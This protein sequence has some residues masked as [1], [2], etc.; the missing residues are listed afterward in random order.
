MFTVDE[1]AKIP[2][3]SALEQN[4]LEYIAGAVEDIHLIPG[5][6]RVAG[7][8]LVERPCAVAV[9]GGIIAAL[10]LRERTA[11]ASAELEAEQ[12]RESGTTSA[13]RDTQPPV[14]AA[15]TQALSPFHV[16]NDIGVTSEMGF[17]Q[18]I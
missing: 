12:G 7:P 6:S 16:A 11:R 17:G 8:L 9:V 1:I 5:E 10:L 15:T 3:F 2:L 18:G 13:C 4:E 14:D